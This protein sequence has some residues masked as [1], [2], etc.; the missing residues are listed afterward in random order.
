[1]NVPGNES[2][3]IPPA[4]RYSMR[5]VREKREGYWEKD[6]EKR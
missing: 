4:G 6:V 3:I 2:S 1:M 5:S